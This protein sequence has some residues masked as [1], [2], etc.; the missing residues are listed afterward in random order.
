MNLSNAGRG[1][2][3]GPA[4]T[5]GTGLVQHGDMADEREATWRWEQA[6]TSGSHTS[7]D[8]TVCIFI[9]LDSPSFNPNQNSSNM[10]NDPR[11]IGCLQI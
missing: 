1:A 11:D 9:C 7:M 3:E 6:S 5:D 8:S 4:A 10:V 2:G